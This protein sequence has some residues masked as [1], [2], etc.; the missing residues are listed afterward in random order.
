VKAGRGSPHGGVY[1]DIATRRD[2]EYIRRRLPSM[3]QQFMELAD[4]D[5]TKTP[6]EV[7]PTAHYQMG[8]VRVEADTTATT[9]PGLFAAGEVAAGMHGANRLGGNSLSDLVVF[10]RR[11]GLHAAQYALGQPSTPAVD[12]AQLEAATTAMLAPFEGDG[13]ENPYTI[14]A[15]LELCMQNLVGI[16][17]TESELVQALDELAKL[18]ARLNRVTVQGNRQYNPGWHLALDLHHM[19]AVAESI[20]RSA[21][22]RKESRGGHTRDDYPGPDAKFGKVNV[23]TRRAEDGI[24]VCQEPLPE[25][26]DELKAIIEEKS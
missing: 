26:P 14:H 10:G 15:D 7:G 11:A 19:L 12:D 4:V 5:I 21:I 20:T 6:M 3:Y 13:N 24:A 18:K 2:P 1:L 16:I 8:G 17:R 9:V 25:I 22:E 23:V